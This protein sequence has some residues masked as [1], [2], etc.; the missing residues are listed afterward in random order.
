M[1]ALLAREHE[2]GALGAAQLQAGA[3]RRR[4]DV[5]AALLDL[6]RADAARLQGLA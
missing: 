1:P 3:Q 6:E 2:R 4:I 5:D